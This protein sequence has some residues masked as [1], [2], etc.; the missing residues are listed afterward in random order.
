MHHRE[1]V[2][3]QLNECCYSKAN[4][5]STPRGQH[6][7]SRAPPAWVRCSIT[8]YELSD[9]FFSRFRA[10]GSQAMSSVPTMHAHNHLQKSCARKSKRDTTLTLARPRYNILGH[11]HSS[12][13][14]VRPLMACISSIDISSN[15]HQ[16]AASRVRDA[17]R[18][19]LAWASQ[20]R[21][22]L[23]DHRIEPRRCVCVS[24]LLFFPQLS[25]CQLTLF[26]SSDRVSEFVGHVVSRSPPPHTDSHTVPKGRSDRV[27]HSETR[28]TSRA[29]ALM[30]D[31]CG[32]TALIGFFTGHRCTADS[33][34]Y[35][36]HGTW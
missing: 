36:A 19:C 26:A 34:R 35:M 9:A 21:S 6:P 31:V 15:H 8:P 12:F 24:D 10:R 1:S 22:E 5:E 18:S 2:L 33:W 3:V 32:R 30:T 23:H 27:A 11:C 29:H 13:L 16:G 28:S 7:F 17:Q 4:N 14:T 25:Q 20:S